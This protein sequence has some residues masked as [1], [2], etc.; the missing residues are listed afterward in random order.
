MICYNKTSPHP[1]ELFSRRRAVIDFFEQLPYGDFDLYG[2]GWPA[3]LQ[4]Y[5]GPIDKKI[6]IMKYY[7]FNFCYENVSATGYISE[8]IFDVFQA[9]TVPVYLGAPNV[10][11]YIPKNCFIDSSDFSDERSLYA[12]LKNM[13]RN[14]YEK[15]M[16][17]IDRFLKTD[18]ALLYSPENFFRIF[19]QL[20]M[21]AQ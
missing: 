5:W 4:N 6:D 10:R 9:G 19:M 1:Q 7:K 20:V 14:E 8:K 16:D 18:K 13:P 12:Y 17:N 3:S 21:E 2:K 15:Y 11:D